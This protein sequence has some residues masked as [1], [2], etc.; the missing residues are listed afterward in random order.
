MLGTQTVGN[1]FAIVTIKVTQ[2]VRFEEPL[3]VAAS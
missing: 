2:Y 3:Q 1:K